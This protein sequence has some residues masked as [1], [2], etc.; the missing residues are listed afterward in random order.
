MNVIDGVDR[1]VLLN[2]EG[3]ATGTAP[4]LEVHSADTPLHLAFSCYITRDDGQVL[5][6][7]RALGK[8]TWPG[9]WTNSCCGHPRPGENPEVAVERRIHE[10]LGMRI[11]KLTIMLPDFRYSATDA[12]GVLENEVCPVYLARTA[13]V[14]RPDPDEVAEYQW[15]SW[16]DVTLAARQT[17]WLLSPWSALQLVALG[18]LAA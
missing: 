15:V 17:P 9:A 12:S 7:R 5:M 1:V 2:E 13:D 11:S 4:R 10:E 16:D 14:P 6:T 3:V 18:E 8:R